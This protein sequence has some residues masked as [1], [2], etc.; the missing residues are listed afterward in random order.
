MNKK[1][2]TS[3]FLAFVM[4]LGIMPFNVFAADNEV[5]AVI[6]APSSIIGGKTIEVS[7]KI[8]NNKTTD[9]NVELKVSG[10]V[11]AVKSASTE[12]TAGGEAKLNVKVTAKD[13]DSEGAIIVKITGANTITGNESIKVNP[14]KVSVNFVKGKNSSKIDIDDTNSIKV[15][16]NS[17]LIDAAKSAGVKSNNSDYS[18]EYTY[19]GVTIK[20][21]AASGVKLD[22]TGEVT[23]DAVKKDEPTEPTGDEYTLRFE[24]Y[25]DTIDEIKINDKKSNSSKQPVKSGDTVE[26]TAYSRY[27]NKN[28]NGRFDK[29]DVTKGSIKYKSG[30]GKYDRTIKFEMPSKDVDLRA[31]YDDEDDKD[32]KDDLKRVYPTNK[33][34]DGRYVEGTLKDYKDTKVYVYKD[35]DAYN[36]GDSALGS[37]YT[38]KNGDYRINVGSYSVSE[39]NDFAYYV[40]EDS[41]SKDDLKQVYPKD[42]ELYGKRDDEY[43]D[44]KGTLKDYPN[45]KI[46]VYLNGNEKG[47]GTTNS[48]GKFDFR[49]SKYIDTKYDEDDL[50][51]YVKS[52][53][54]SAK[55]FVTRALAGET[56]VEGKDAGKDANVEIQDSSKIKLGSTTA[57]RDGKFTVTLNRALRGGETITIIAKESG[58]NEVKVDYIVP[59]VSTGETSS[60]GYIE[61]YE[62]GSFKPNGNM[63]RAE[64]ATM[65]A[66][67]MN[68]SNNFGTSNITRFY[69][70]NNEWYSKAVN[71]AVGKGI[72]NGYPDGSFKPNAQITRAEFTQMLSQYVTKS[73]N[74]AANFNDINNHWAKAAIVKVY[75]N[76]IIDGYPDGSFRPDA[77]ITRAEAVKMLNITFNKTG[78]TYTNTFYDVKASDWFYNDVM[79]AAN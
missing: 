70:A 56:K 50:K 38:D 30:Y 60:K 68:G 22:T 53:K 13:L 52:D 7:A 32:D 67:L 71:Y 46:Y 43:R 25:S 40:D 39:F 66:R 45:E 26:V 59:G 5:S 74:K 24:R 14:S 10:D 35:R 12:V 29:W 51:F 42:I 73:G 37:G 9:A 3:L 55:P 4:V 69:D 31:L 77:N 33:E 28:S 15:D 57:D 78:G 19:K 36:D 21:N 76:N 1:K 48:D 6:T 18:L 72:I 27:K 54:D 64:A 62:D 23:V 16:Y 17:S 2:W 61:G 8:K 20:E 79:K 11:D 63:T 44:V 41:K 34:K 58:K 65:M 75:N 49:L 47:N